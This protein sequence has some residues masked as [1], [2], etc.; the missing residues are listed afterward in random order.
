MRYATYLHLEQGEGW[1][2]VEIINP[3]KDGDILQRYILIPQG[4]EVPTHK[5]EGVVIRTPL[6]RC[7]FLS[8]PHAALAIEL[9]AQDAIAG[10]SDT[11]YII[12]PA[13][14]KMLH[15]G[16]VVSLGSSMQPDKERIAQIAADALFASPY[17]GGNLASN[18]PNKCPIILCAD[19]M[20]TSALGRAEWMK[21]YG[22][23]WGKSEMADSLFNA[24][25]EGYLT[26]CRHAEQ[27]TTRPRLMCD[28]K[29]GASW[30]MPGGNSYLGK[31]FADAGAEYIFAHRPENGSVFLSLEEVLARGA[32]SDVWMIK[33]GARHSATY[34]SLQQALPQCTAFK[35]YN[36]G[37]V[38]HCN[39]LQKPYYEEVPFHPERLLQ[40]II[41]LLHPKSF[42]GYEP[43]YYQKMTVSNTTD[44]SE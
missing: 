41:A 23:L 39:T 16:D 9:N 24:V 21:F 27:T 44:I 6:D 36:E 3:W 15:T 25:E 19:Y 5:P 37:N 28:M 12:S 18:L 40:D 7:A 26:L 13:L 43:R 22:M 38:W 33:Y 30:P 32:H 35:A 10:I 1:T 2:C 31:L 17:E 14:R 11:A 42:P 8:A 20:E 29:Q 4:E 34:E